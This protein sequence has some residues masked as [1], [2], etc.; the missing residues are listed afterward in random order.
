MRWIVRSSRALGAA[1]L[2]SLLA[3]G[4]AGAQGVT[5]GAITGK[6]SDAQ[7]RPL[8]QADVQ[9]VHRSTGFS[10][11][12]RTRAN[13]LFLV[14]GLEVGG[15]Y[16]VTVRAIGHQ[17]FVRN[18]VYVK[19]SEATPV[20]VQLTAQAVELSAVTVIGSVTPDFA[21][22]RQGVSTQISDT[23]VSRIPTFSRD[24][25]DQLKLSPQVVYAASG[26]P[27]GNGA[28]N[29]FNTIT[30]DGANQS[31]RFNLNATGSVPGGSA[32]GKI[33]S[34][35]AVKEFRVVFTP[36]DVRQGNFAGMLVNAVTKSGTNEYHGGGLFTYRNS[37]DL[38]GFNLVGERLRTPT[39]DVKQYGFHA[40]GP[41]IRDRLHFFVA[42]EWQQ[43]AQPAAGPYYLGGNASPAPDDPVVPLTKLDSIRTVMQAR[44]F[45]VGSTEP[46]DN[47]TPLINLFGRLD[48]QISPVH[49]FVVRQ[50]IN[51]ADQDE[52]FRNV[53][54]YSA[55]PLTQNAGFRF[56]SNG[57]VTQARNNSTT[58]QLYSNFSSGK[59]NELIVGYSTIHYE[60]IVP[61]RA[62]EITVGWQRDT[63]T[64]FPCPCLVG[65]R[66]SVTF[67]TEQFS[68]GNLLD[69]KIFEAVDNFTIPMGAHTITVGGRVDRTHIYNNFAQGLYGVYKFFNIDSLRLSR[70]TG[71]AVGYPNS[72]RAE[73]IPADFRV[74]VYSVYAQD[75]WS[76]TDR[77][78]V[79]AG[80]R[81][82]IPNLLDTPPQ[83]DTLTNA[84]AARGLTGVRTDVTPKSSALLSPRL[85]FNYDATGDHQ[86]QIRGSIGIYTGPPPYILL[87][88]A[89]ANTG[90]GLV[91]LSCN[92]STPTTQAPAFTVD[93]TALPTAC[94]GQTAPAPGA[95]GTVGV[96]VNDPNFKF[97]QYLGLSAGFDRQ[98]P[99][100]TVL[101]VEAI[102]RKAI[103][104][105]LVRDLNLKGPRLVS[106]VPY[107]DRD[108]RVLYADT[109]L[110]NGT[111]VDTLQR[112]LTSLRGAAFS[113]GIIEATNQSKD[114]NYSLSTQLHRRFSDRFEATVAYTYMKSKDVQSLTSD[115]A[116]SNFRFGR[117]LSTS[118]DG[119]T[120]TTSNFSRPHRVLAYGTYTLP[121][122]LTDVTLYYEGTSGV[123]F[124]YVAGGS[125]SLGDL[126]GDLVNGNDPIYVPRDATD[127]SEIRIGTGVGAA[128]SQN[129]AAAQAFNKF[130]E[131]QPCLDR[132]RGR[133]MERN[134]CR[135]PFQHRLDLSIRQSIP[136]LHGQQLALQLDFFNLLNFLNKD[137]GQNKLPTLSA[138][139]NNQSAL[140]VTGRNPGPL[141]QSIPTFTF[142]TRLYDATTGNAKPFANRTGS[143]YQIQLSLRYT[144]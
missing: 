27:S 100:N 89:Y 17:P 66:R 130:I 18:D 105:V 48:F 88:N 51:H 84:L 79:T 104:G 60:R 141:S 144:F 16:S 136:Q 28:Y 58:A 43:R 78:T 111:V 65:L 56:S 127:P 23:L 128:F 44:G 132:Q 129:V 31:E 69:Q 26:G 109:V 33:V 34:L 38:L 113:E 37:D 36:T 76:V 95:A 41:I 74:G 93:V 97:P 20:D 102:Y 63:G 10:T 29:R 107:T 143:V 71:Y 135:T 70:P 121:W 87:G 40:G 96:N 55:D 98:L 52:F 81:A 62:P 118:H 7:G 61:V 39:F 117:Q 86:N 106:G 47:E 90:L 67:G 3:A 12:A 123:P 103:N 46:I 64:V 9:V 1:A 134:S 54:T 120:A 24:F 126:N 142:D 75:Q 45:E 115:R 131:N 35:D 108:G 59:S 19:L 2:F 49:R 92:G 5:T 139:N 50:I 13:G 99:Y 137:W 77:L 8:A 133:I 82:D 119:L 101:T 94:A 85:G 42:P 125:L 122:R 22:T 53:Q 110:A 80:L 6:V 91:R 68:P 72:G 14:Q 4:A 140:V 32:G 57:F 116:I 83:N 21:P 11:G 73:D 25:I 124:V 114:F 30:I 15:P 138:T 112:W